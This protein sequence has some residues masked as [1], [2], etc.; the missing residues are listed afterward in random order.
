M[1]PAGIDNQKVTLRFMG[2][3]GVVTGSK[4][5]LETPEINVLIDC[6][7]FQGLKNLR[8]L[9][10]APLETD[11]YAI[12]AVI[13]THAHLDHTGYLPVLVRNGFKGKI[14]LTDP[15]RILTEIILLDSAKLQEEDADHANKMGYSKHT[16]ALPLYTQTETK[17][18]FSHF[19]SCGHDEWI[20]L[21]EHV[22]FRFKKNGHILGSCFVE[23]DYFG[24][25]IVF[26]GDLGRQD[27]YS[28]A[29][30][31]TPEKADVL[32]VESTYGD[33]LH[34]VTNVEQ[35]LSEIINDTVHKKGTLLIPSFAV[36][37]A[38]DLMLLINILK[39]KH[40]IP[41]I[42]V[43]L[44]SPM[45]TEAT[46]A[47]E[48]FSAWH[49]LNPAQC[50]EMWNNITRVKDLKETY[51]VIDQQGSKVVIAASG[52]L[53]GGRV[54]HYLRSYLGHAQH[55]I[56]LVGYQA[57]G[58]RGRAL[59][60]GVHELKLFGSYFPVKAA[61]KEIATLSAHAD[62]HELISWMKAIPNRPE[63]VFIVHGEP[64]ASFALELKIHDA[65]GWNAVV[66][67]LN[68]QFELT[69]PGKL[70]HD[71]ANA[72]SAVL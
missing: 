19:Q 56:L 48:D 64:E 38:Q 24:K 25:R 71:I 46:K 65:L 10:R 53:T 29:P 16:P 61:V 47:Y 44:D 37:R 8:Q 1:I 2:A 6:G 57:S 39:K 9:N 58:T 59:R 31:L 13:I 49:K 69:D 34:P 22:R 28:L 5:L 30:P 54:L 35:E 60:S 43:Y 63:R 21:S 52:M 41:D 11:V 33:R 72:H 12:N 36:G 23:M 66:P 67:I 20:I 68:E 7:L 27:S 17:E 15:T 55:T 4:H 62:Q 14:Y 45:S 40:F 18:T 32:V 51:K 26:S 70:Q 3:A 42:P 50:G